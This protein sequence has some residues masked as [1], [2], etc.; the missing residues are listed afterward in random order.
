MIKPAQSIRWR[1]TLWLA[2]LLICVLTGFG[3]TAYQ[4]HRTNRFDQLDDELERRVNAL[5]TALRTPP[6]FR[7]SRGERFPGM[8]PMPGEPPPNLS[9]SNWPARGG[10]PPRDFRPGHG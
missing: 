5:S 7:G 8:R 1:F 2:F 3:F 6:D 9:P 4:L 10:G